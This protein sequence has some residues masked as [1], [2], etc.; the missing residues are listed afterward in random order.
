MEKPEPIPYDD[1]DFDDEEHDDEAG[2]CDCGALHDDT[3]LGGLCS[4]CGGIV[5]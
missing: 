1:Y 3:E 5:D 4:C 2:Y